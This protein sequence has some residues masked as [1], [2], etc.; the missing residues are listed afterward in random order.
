MPERATSS[1]A[2]SS[3]DL[4]RHRRSLPVYVGAGG[5][6]TASHYAFVIGA[7]ELFGIPPIV[8]T[9]LGFALGAA[10]KYWLNYTAAFASRAAHSQAMVRFVVTLATLMAVN[11]ACF[12]LLSAKLGMHYLVAQAI[13]TVAL[14]P[15]GYYIH[16]HWVFRA[17]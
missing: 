13:V 16:R 17:C 12:Y 5:I 1:A 14:I 4:P 9:T 2:A 15:P 8:A 6:A 10:I 11:A 7:V 3:K